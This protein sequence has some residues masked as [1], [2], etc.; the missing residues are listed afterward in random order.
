[1]VE[2][3][4]T[5]SP[6]LAF[7]LATIARFGETGAYTWL[8]YWRDLRANDVSVVRRLGTG[9]RRRVLRRLGRRAIG[10][11]SCRTPRAPRPRSTS[12]TPQPTEPPTAVV[13]D[14]CFRQIEFAGVLAGAKAPDLARAFVDFMLSTDFQQDIPLNMFVFPAN[15]DDAAARRLQRSSRPRRPHR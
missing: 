13:T 3:P 8:D 6:G 9:L 12:P 2:N 14:G 7:M 5:S 4:A 15:R 11:S 10:R 1:M